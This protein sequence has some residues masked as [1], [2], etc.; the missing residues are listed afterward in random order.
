MR[1][2]SVTVMGWGGGGLIPL[3]SRFRL[4]FIHR[5]V[6]YSD[7]CFRSSYCL[8]RN[9]TAL[10]HTNYYVKLTPT[11]LF[12]YLSLLTHLVDGK[13]YFVVN[14]D[15]TTVGPKR[16]IYKEITIVLLQR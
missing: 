2:D 15:P 11:L 3:C 9:I 7:T 6:G 10:I 4:H 5:A 12:F 13:T 14:R 1:K 8:L 16:L